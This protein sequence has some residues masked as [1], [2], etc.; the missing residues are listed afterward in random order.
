[1]T[2]RTGSCSHMIFLIRP[3]Y[4]FNQSRLRGRRHQPSSPNP[5]D[6]KVDMFVRGTESDGIPKRWWGDRSEQRALSLKYPSSITGCLSL[7]GKS[8]YFISHLKSQEVWKVTSQQQIFT[9][10]NI[11]CA[12]TCEKRDWRAAGNSSRE[13]E[14]FVGGVGGKAI[15]P[16]VQIRVWVWKTSIEYQV[17]DQRRAVNLGHRTKMEAQ[18]RHWIGEPSTLL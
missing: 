4:H 2:I 9:L 17:K 14:R 3:V 8:A 13:P 15:H 12:I 10:I 5:S 6:V 16:A 7:T 1:M 18:K 11:P